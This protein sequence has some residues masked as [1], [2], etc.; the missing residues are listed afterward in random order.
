MLSETFWS[1]LAK[2]RLLWQKPFTQ[3]ANHDPEAGK[4]RW[5]TDGVINVSENCVDRHAEKNPER[6]A[7]IW[8]KD[9]PGTEERMTYSNVLKD[10]GVNKGDRV[11]IYL[12]VMPFAVATMLACTRIGAIHSVVFAG[13][14]AEALASRITDAQA[15]T[16]ITADQAVRGGKTI[17]LKKTVDEAVSRCPSVKRVFVT[18]R[19]GAKVKKTSK[20]IDI[21][22]AVVNASPNCPASSQN[23]EDLL[24]ILYTSGSTGK[25]KGIAHSTAGYLLYASVTHK[26]VFNY[27]END[28]YGCV[29]DIGWI[30]GHSYAVYGPLANGATTVLFES[31]PTYPD[32][33]IWE[34][35]SRLG[36][37]Q[38]Y[39]APTAI[40][41]LL[42]SGDSWPAK[43]DLTSLRVLGSVG[44]P[45]NQEAWHWYNDVIG[46]KKCDV[47]DTWWQT[48][49]GGI[50]I[51][52]RPS[53]P[54][55]KINAGMPMRPMFGIGLEL[56][57]LSGNIVNE[58][59]VD[60]ALCIRSIWPGIARTV[61]GDHQRYLETYFKPYPGYF[62]SGD[63]AVRDEEGYY[64]MSGRMD[65]VIN[66]TGHR[67]GTAEVEDVMNEHV[68]IAETAVVGFPHEIKG[69]GGLRL[70]YPQERCNRTSRSNYEG[71]KS[72]G[73]IADSSLCNTRKN[74]YFGLPK[75]RSVFISLASV[76]HLKK[77]IEKY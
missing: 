4:F 70:R 52:P 57:D 31:T 47:V 50:M 25:P 77:L 40:R 51:S 5:F 23:A 8:E 17:E 35:V 9:E 1:I 65:D 71:W 69:E 56:L 43:Y 44:E 64:Q 74:S 61:Y 2:E 59:K 29:A 39:C 6:V 60:G 34:T 42:R 45:L 28:I 33:D 27:K 14:S 63:A 49:T 37:N 26:H 66:V 53:A 13:F 38:F 41:L 10:A 12:P 21:D 16:V 76:M 73:S 67:L 7:L 68:S 18:S 30:T 55:A 15:E 46:K 32:P 24:F 11:A 3:V 48:E 58:N 75:T 19:T 62:F 20:D 72:D 22:K 54:N 36:I